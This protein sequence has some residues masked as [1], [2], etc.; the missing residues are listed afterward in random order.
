[1]HKITDTRTH[2]RM[3]SFRLVSSV[4]NDF[5]EEIMWEVLF[6][7]WFRAWSQQVWPLLSVKSK[8]LCRSRAHGNRNGGTAGAK[9]ELKCAAGW[10]VCACAFKTSASNFQPELLWTTDRRS[11]PEAYKTIT[12]KPNKQHVLTIKSIVAKCVCWMPAQ[13]KR[14]R[15]RAFHQRIPLYADT[16]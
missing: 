12:F 10:E 7:F 8:W 14:N 6:R 2:T 13:F 4:R 5:G 3:I 11:G 16:N 15:R 9:K 1:M